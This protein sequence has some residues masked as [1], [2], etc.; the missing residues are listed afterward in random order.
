MDSVC[1]VCGMEHTTE[2]GANI[3]QTLVEVFHLRGNRIDDGVC[4]N[5]C[6]R[7]VQGRDHFHGYCPVCGCSVTSHIPVV[8]I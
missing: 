6:A 7:L 3:C 4:P 1:P 2:D 8:I 5:G